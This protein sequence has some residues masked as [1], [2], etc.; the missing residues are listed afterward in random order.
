MG[1]LDGI[2][3]LDLTHYV[4]G[5]FCTLLLA[6]QGAEVVKLEPPG[7]D[8]IRRFPSS[9]EGESRLFLGLNRGKRS[10]GVD[11]SREEGRRAARALA[12]RADVL[13]EGFRPGVAARL[14]L[15]A[16]EVRALNPRL[17]YA[18]ISAYGQAG[19][20]SGRRGIDPIVQ[21]FAGIPA[22]QGGGGPPQLVQGHFLDYFTGALA[23]NAIAL[24]LLERERTGE[25]RRV[26]ASLLGSAAALQQGRLVWAP[27]RE[28]RENVRDLLGDRLARIYETADGHVYLYLD[29]DGFWERAL[30]VLGLERLGE[31]ARF[32]TFRGRHA[33]RG[34]LVPQIQEILRGAP[35][36]AWVERFEGAGVPCAKV[37][38]P[39]ELFGEEQLRAMG[40]L[41]EVRH[42]G[43][44]PLR[45][46]G[47]SFT[48]EGL[49]GGSALPPPRLGEHTGEVLQE[50]GFTPGEIA[51]WRAAGVVF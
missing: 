35:S 3:V 40:M 18:S 27:D 48:L 38:W 41:R 7:G 9:F 28:P 32:Q 1:A 25:G 46:M 20:L 31:D 45:V 49:P 21:T 39:W 11:L 13:A 29:V 36:D 8:A 44:G 47:P 42:P 34:E 10:I 22:E 6:D 26:E 12:A 24:A 2:R 43:Y 23:A 50:A 19:P 33:G 17:V 30:A 14:G 15:G 51:G 4:A 5:P 16:E 37:R